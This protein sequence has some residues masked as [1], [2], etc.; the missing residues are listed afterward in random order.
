MRE[1]IRNSTLSRE[2]IADK[3][4]LI[5][6][7]EGLGGGRGSTVSAANLDAW[8]SETKSN[9]IPLHLLPIF[10]RVVGDLTPLKVLAHPLD[11]DVIDAKEARLL[12][13]AK[14]EVQAKTLAKRKKK[15]LSEIEGVLDEH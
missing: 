11:G 1:A 4:R 14:M 7:I 13:W 15:I 3:M 10:C 2:E 9:L 8:C 12:A 6:G 5:A